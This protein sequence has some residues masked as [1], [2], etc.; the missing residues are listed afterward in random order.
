MI[1]VKDCKQRRCNKTKKVKD[2]FLNKE[3]GTNRC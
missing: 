3:D 2:S 1:P